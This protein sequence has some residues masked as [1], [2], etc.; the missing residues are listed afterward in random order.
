MPGYLLAP[1][2]PFAQEPRKSS[3]F[4]QSELCDIKNEVALIVGDWFGLHVAEF[5]GLCKLVQVSSRIFHPAGHY[6][7][8]WQWT[9]VRVTAENCPMLSGIGIELALHGLG[10]GQS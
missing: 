3:V 8:L 6:S 5:W 10:K 2:F 7:Y 9:F 1:T 4:S